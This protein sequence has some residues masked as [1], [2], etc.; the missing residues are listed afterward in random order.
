MLILF[1][2]LN[3]FIILEKSWEKRKFS[4]TFKQQGDLQWIAV[5]RPCWSERTA[6]LVGHA[7][8]KPVP[9]CVWPRPQKHGSWSWTGPWKSSCPTS[10]RQAPMELWISTTI[11]QHPH[12]WTNPFWIWYLSQSR[13]HFHN[14]CICGIMWEQNMVVGYM[15]AK[16]ACQNP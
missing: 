11:H 2:S 7:F 9:D 14:T 1:H 5:W 16:Y 8:I 13:Y 15:G 6:P 4:G 12:V 10:L 3:H